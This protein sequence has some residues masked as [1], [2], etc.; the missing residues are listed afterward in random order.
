M[1]SEHTNPVLFSVIIDNLFVLN[2]KK[3]TLLLYFF[4][5]FVD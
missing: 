1:S 2:L 4:P 5:T 3:L